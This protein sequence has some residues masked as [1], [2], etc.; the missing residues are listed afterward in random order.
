MFQFAVFIVC[1]MPLRFG[2]PSGVRGAR[3]AGDAGA[4]AATLVST[5]S[6]QPA[7]NA[8]VVPISKRFRII[9]SPS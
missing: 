2:L 5:G 3:Y 8:R 1:Q 7:I 9:W 4:C 6:S